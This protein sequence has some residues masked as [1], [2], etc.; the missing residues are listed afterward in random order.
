MRNVYASNVPKHRHKE[1]EIVEAK[2]EELH[3]W[4]KFEAYE[5]V[6]DEGQERITSTWNINQKEQHDSLKVQYKARLCLRG[7]MEDEI[8]RSDSPTASREIT[9]A[10]LAIGSNEN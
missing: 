2:E 4:L 7:F 5:I 6:D 10:V 1:P 3:N 8:P 9:K